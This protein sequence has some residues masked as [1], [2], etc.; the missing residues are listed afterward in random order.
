MIRNIIWDVDGTLFDTYPA[1]AR[2]FQAALSDFGFS[3][4]VE[5]IRELAKIS[6]GHCATSLA[7][8]YQINEDELAAKFNEHYDR[9]KPDE[10][11]PFPGVIPICEYICSIG[12]KNVIVTHR[13]Q[14]GTAELL[15]ANKMSVLFAGAITRND[16]YAK[17]P[18]SAAFEA[19]LRI[20]GLEP[21]ETITAGD[22]EIDITAG[23]H[24]GLF[25]CYFGENQS[26]AELI[27][28]HFSELFEFILEKNK[29]CY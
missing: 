24:A 5:W 14:V 25:S 27:I 11:P 29:N 13:G 28:H 17:K 10:Q 23:Q 9:V 15:E 3:A 8:Q 21:D 1:I 20:Y 7:D 16:G 4:P 22:R 19:A 6:L 18:D 26:G 2:S 12:G